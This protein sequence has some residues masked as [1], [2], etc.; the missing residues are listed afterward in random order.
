MLLAL[1]SAG[2]QSLPPLPTS[3]LGPSGG[4]SQV[5]GFVY[6]LEPCGSLQQTLLWG[7]EFI[8]PPLPPYILQPEVL[9]L[10]FFHAGTLGFAVCHA[11]QLFPLAYLHS[12][13]GPPGPP[14]ITS[15]TWSFSCCLALC[16]LHPSFPSPP[17]LPVWKNVPLTPW[18]SDLHTV[19][20][21]DS[22]GCFFV[23][24]LN[25]LGFFVCKEAK[26]IYLCLCLDQKSLHCTLNGEKSLF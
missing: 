13:V 23:V 8:L 24:V 3:T 2:C 12:N 7:W 10:F 18:F 11:L 19:Q 4:D 21:S 6:I 5:G 9:R 16:P 15:P 17:L 1:L 14:A 25:W 22:S 20:F 26:C